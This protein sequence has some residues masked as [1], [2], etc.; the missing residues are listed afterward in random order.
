MNEAT[1]LEKACPHLTVALWR[2]LVLGGPVA[3]A[4]ER[5]FGMSLGLAVAHLDE[6]ADDAAFLAEVAILWGC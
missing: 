6:A 3:I 4:S 1:G 2:R 5:F